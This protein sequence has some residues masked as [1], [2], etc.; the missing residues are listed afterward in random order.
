MRVVR[1]DGV[2]SAARIKVDSPGKH[3]QRIYVPVGIDFQAG[4]H[5]AVV[6]GNGFGPQQRT[7]GGVFGDEGRIGTCNIVCA[8]AWVKIG[9]AVENAAVVDVARRVGRHGFGLGTGDGCGRQR[10]AK[11]RDGPDQPRVFNVVGLSDDGDYIGHARGVDIA[12]E[13][14]VRADVFGCEGTEPL[15]RLKLDVIIVSAANS[16]EAIAAVRVGGSR[17]HEH[18][19][20]VARR[21]VGRLVQQDGHARQRRFIR[22]VQA[23][24]VAIVED[25]AA[26]GRLSQ[27]Q[28]ETLIASSRDVMRARTWIE[29]DGKAEAAGEENVVRTVHGDAV[30]FVVVGRSEGLGPSRIALGV[31][32][33][34]IGV[35]PSGGGDVYWRLA[36]VEI[37]RALERSSNVGVAGRVDGNARGSCAAG[38]LVHLADPRKPSCRIDLLHEYVFGREITGCEIIDAGKRRIEIGRGGKYARRVDVARRINGDA[39]ALA[40]PKVVRIVRGAGPDKVAGRIQLQQEFA[41]EDGTVP[42]VRARSRIEIDA[43]GKHVA[44]KLPCYID[45]ARAVDCNAAGFVLAGSANLLGPEEITAGVVFGHQR[46]GAAC[47]CKQRSSAG[48]YRRIE[49]AGQI[50]I[51]GGING[52][53]IV[54]IAG[55]CSGPVGRPFERTGRAEF[56]QK[57]RIRPAPIRQHGRSEGRRTVEASRDVDIAGRIQGDLRIGLDGARTRK[58]REPL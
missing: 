48:V 56:G 31:E 25:L 13:R 3:A 19:I 15:G 42:K 39:H 55:P 9:R 14:A 34:K 16:D 47:R 11:A 50:G 10:E 32:L 41:A 27:L 4:K 18:V 35:Q 22:I 30:A 7:G 40:A 5:L 28:Q 20:A 23:V 8:G 44:R 29:I 45:V 38:G 43:V 12:V 37:G 24:A 46:V 49:G 54:D 1:R 26:D 21:R 51:A 2:S 57:P 36:P 33:P 6:D 52:K 53:P 58:R 17:G